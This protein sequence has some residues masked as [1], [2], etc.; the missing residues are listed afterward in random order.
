MLSGQHNLKDEQFDV[1]LWPCDL[2]NY[3]VG[4][5]T[6]PSLVTFQQRV[7]RY[8][9]DQSLDLY[10][11]PCDLKIN[12]KHLFSTGIHCTK[13]GNFPAKDREQRPVVWSW[14]DLW[15]CDHKIIRGHLLPGVIHCSLSTFQRRSQEIL[16]KDHQQFDLDFTFDHQ[17]GSC[18]S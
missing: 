5:F 6:L 12:K 4:V 16:N 2:N 17:S 14:L 18:T 13:F 3:C 11:W 1:D 15:L 7:K 8:W 9:A 10:L